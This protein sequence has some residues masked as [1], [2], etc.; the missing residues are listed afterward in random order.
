MTGD[1]SGGGPVRGY[2]RKIR[3]DYQKSVEREAI[4]GVHGRIREVVEPELCGVVLDLGSGGVTEYRPGRIE[5]LVSMDNV[6]EFLKNSTNEAAVNLCGDVT[7]IPLREAS[8]D[9]IIMQHV[10]H[11]LTA[12]R[13]EQNVRNVLAASAEAARILRP[14][15]VL[16]LIDS[17]TPS[18][19]ERFQAWAYRLSHAALRMLNKPMVFFFS[20][21]RLV[22]I[23]E[24]SGLRVD[25]VLHIDWGDM[26]EASQALFPWLRF[27]LRYTPIKCILVSAGRPSGERGAGPLPG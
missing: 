21:A 8:V 22:R 20:T 15:G 12:R 5:L 3:S 1:D 10:L 18:L 27:P 23:L 19:L 16:F 25:R 4:A 6:L 2:F 7:A 9:F 11:H 17:M 13:Y 24:G 14:G 26:T